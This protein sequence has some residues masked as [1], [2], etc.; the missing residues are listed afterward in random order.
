MTIQD[1][2]LRERRGEETTGRLT[3]TVPE[4]ARLLGIARGSAYAAIQRGE[5]NAVRIGKRLLVP[6]AALQRLLEVGA[7]G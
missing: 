2:K 5:L 6:R 4:A 3:F 7:N 1:D